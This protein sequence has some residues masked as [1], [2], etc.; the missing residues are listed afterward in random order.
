MGFAYLNG[1][2]LPL[3]QARVS[4]LDRGFLFGDGVYEVIPAYGGR[5]FRL[6][7]HL[8]RLDNSL[9]AI[10]MTPPHSH[11]DWAGILTRLLDPERT[12]DQSVYLQITRGTAPK[13]DH[14][15]PADV[16]P[17]VFAMATPIPPPDPR[18]LE[19]GVGAVTHADLRWLRCDIKAITLL[20]NVLL[21]QAA[22]DAD[23]MEAILVRE[24]L[25]TEG[26]ASNL[27]VVDG[28]VI[29]TPP[30]GPLLLPGVTRDLVLELAREAGL[31]HREANVPESLLRIASEIWLSSSTKEIL[32]V[33]TLDGQ[34]VGDG[35]PGPVWRRMS[36]LYQAFKQQLRDTAAR[37]P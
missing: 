7:Q 20:A 15:I 32:P 30:K 12:L 22:A 28:G 6:A 18:N 24:G 3:E 31:P 19:R 34:S 17:T 5:L 25:A 36:S 10:R 29:L 37:S 4:V 35:R 8:K 23:A 33:T 26:A 21:R 11:H 1:E 9:R 13:R 2:F 14:A 27:F 16:A